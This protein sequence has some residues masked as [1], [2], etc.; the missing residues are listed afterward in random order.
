[1]RNSTLLLPGDPPAKA[2]LRDDFS[3]PLQPCYQAEAVETDIIAY[4]TLEP[5]HYRY[6]IYLLNGRYEKVIPNGTMGRKQ[7][8]RGRLLRDRLLAFI[9]G[10][11]IEAGWRIATD[12]PG[13]VEKWRWEGAVAKEREERLAQ[14][15]HKIWRGRGSREGNEKI[16]DFPE[17]PL[18]FELVSED[19]WHPVP[20]DDHLEYRI[21][22]DAQQLR[23]RRQRV[24]PQP[25]EQQ[26][27]PI[28]LVLGVVGDEGRAQGAGPAYHRTITSRPITFVCRGCKQEVT[29]ERLPGPTPRYCSDGCRDEVTREKTLKRV[30]R[31]R[32]ER[33][34]SEA[35]SETPPS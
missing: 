2:R 8:A 32:A 17:D 15:T 10:Q 18:L 5:N 1:M 26:R 9:K 35:L 33:K 24:I 16:A 19:Q 25:Q 7:E 14:L 34:K 29:Q 28:T 4:A 31:L 27:T 11:L 23:V 21:D 6:G 20:G 3:V 30:R 13:T 22:S 12:E